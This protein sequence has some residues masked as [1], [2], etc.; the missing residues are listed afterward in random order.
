MSSQSS[1]FRQSESERDAEGSVKGSAQESDSRSPSVEEIVATVE[2]P[3]QSQPRNQRRTT[4]EDSGICARKC[5]LTVEEFRKAKRLA[6][7]PGM[8]VR[9]PTPEE[10]VFDAPPGFFTI[11]LKSLE[12]G[13]RFPLHQ[14][15]KDFFLH[16]DFLPCQVVPKSHR[17]LAGFLIQCQRTGVRR[18]LAHFLLLFRVA[19]SSGRANSDSGSYASIFQRQEKL[20]K[21]RK[22]SAKIGSLVTNEALAALGFVFLSLEDTQRSIEEGPSGEIMLSNAERVKLMFPDAPSNSSQV[23]ASGGR[24][25]TPPVKPTSETAQKKKRKETASVADAPQG[26]ESPMMKDFG[27]RLGPGCYM[28]DMSQRLRV[29]EDDQTR[30]YVE[31]ADLNEELKAAKEQA[32]QAKEQARQ[33]EEAARKAHQEGRDQVVAEFLTLPKGRHSLALRDVARQAKEAARKAHQEG[34]DQVVAE[35]LASDTFQEEAFARMNDLIK[36][37]GQTPERK[38][39]ARSEGRRGTT[40]VCS[41]RSKSFRTGLFC[42]SD[43][44]EAELAPPPSPRDTWDSDS[45]SESVH[46]DP[47]AKIPGFIYYSSEEDEK[48]PSPLARHEVAAPPVPASRRGRGRRPPAPPAAVPSESS[49]ES[50]HPS[51][52]SIED[53][54]SPSFDESTGHSVVSRAP[55]PPSYP[56]LCPCEQGWNCGMH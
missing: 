32:Q 41:E 14:L 15:V 13:F 8:T 38:A 3:P 45:E 16:F 1:V 43:Q 2:V 30:A 42:H 10:S 40:L 34:R 23:P 29:S 21:T 28:V 31:I 17:Y 22:D 50:H 51:R 36:A 12:Y 4:L 37:W 33:A 25:P 54:G 55:S 5:T 52:H 7:A 11:H 20:F 27:N 19:K 18:D 47:F 48:T 35:F 26:S 44:V 56:P 9:R 49:V 39:F 6:S 46:P 24:P 53:P